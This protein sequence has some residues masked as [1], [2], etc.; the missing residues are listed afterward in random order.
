M[1]PADAARLGVD[2]GDVVQ[3]QIDSDGRDLTFGDVIVR[4]SE[5]FRLELHLDADEANAAE[6]TGATVR[7]KLVG[8]A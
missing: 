5:S 8:H 6:V 7:A 1:S 4:V 3:V 2:D